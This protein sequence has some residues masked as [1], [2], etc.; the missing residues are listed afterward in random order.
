MQTI[1]YD[2]EVDEV[3][4]SYEAELG[5]PFG[6]WHERMNAML[7]GV[8]GYDD[9]EGI[10]AVCA[11]LADS[12]RIESRHPSLWAG[13]LVAMLAALETVA[14]EGTDPDEVSVAG[15]DLRLGD[16]MRLMGTEAD[17]HAETLRR[18]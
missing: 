10:A 12:P 4:R 2:V 18:S 7:A 3:L 9:W 14:T 15:S 16:L 1:V 8:F 6:S 13:L 5:H 17:R 11:Q